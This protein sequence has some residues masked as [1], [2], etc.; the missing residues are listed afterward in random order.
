MP[1]LQAVATW[2]CSYPLAPRYRP[3]AVASVVVVVVL[4]NSS[5]TPE[6]QRLAH[7]LAAAAHVV[8]LDLRGHGRSKG[9]STLGRCALGPA[10]W[11]GAGDPVGPHLVNP[12]F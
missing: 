9:R 5:R 2:A 1:P 7:E 12:L 3:P 6:V 11:C 4:S 8:A 10:R